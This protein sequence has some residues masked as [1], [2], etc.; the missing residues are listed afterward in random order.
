MSGDTVTE[1]LSVA[2]GAVHVTTGEHVMISAGHAVST[3]YS[4]SVT[5]T[6]NEQLEEFPKASVPVTV[7]TVVPIANVE[8]EA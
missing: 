8:P 4:E 6:L 1:Q 5:T 3:G 2:V 7:T